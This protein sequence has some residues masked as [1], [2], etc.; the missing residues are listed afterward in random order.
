[1][2]RW[3][4]GVPGFET[5]L[6]HA[7]RADVDELSQGVGRR[8]WGRLAEGV[9]RVGTNR[10][11]GSGCRAAPGELADSL[12]DSFDVRLIEAVHRGLPLG[13]GRGWRGSG[14]RR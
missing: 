14:G 3:T 9:G 6:W 7:I 10:L 8:F 5:K 11:G 12:H 13:L 4:K 2:H 1:M